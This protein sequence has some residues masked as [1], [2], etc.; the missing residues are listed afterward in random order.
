MYRNRF[1]LVAGPTGAG[2]STL[3]DEFIHPDTEYFN[4]D[5]VFAHFAGKYPHLSAEQLEGGVAGALEKSIDRAI[6]KQ[7]DFAFETN[8]S[9][10]MAASVAR[11]F[12]ENNFTIHLIYV[13][14][15][16]LKNCKN[17]VAKRVVS[18]GHNVSDAQ[19]EFN[20]HEGI[21]RV[22]EHLS[23]FDGIT[24]LDNMTERRK[25]IA[26]S[27]KGTGKFI[28]DESCS[29]FNRYFKSSFDKLDVV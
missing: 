1:T 27:K 22:V 6:E 12:K 19:I 11:K 10:D 28:V 26:V 29:W 4:G 17:R 25:I 15:D 23:L 13:G 2:K 18:G 16:S 20:Y 7:W 5:I 3:T 9:S 8:F 14:I 24:F 21:K